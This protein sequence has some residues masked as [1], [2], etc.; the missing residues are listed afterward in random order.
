MGFILS[1][2]DERFSPAALSLRTVEQNCDKYSA[3]D[4]LY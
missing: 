3:V 1:L 4:Q 2:T